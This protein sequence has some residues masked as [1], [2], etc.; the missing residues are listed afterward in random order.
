MRMLQQQ[1]RRAAARARV[2]RRH[3]AQ[4]AGCGRLMFSSCAT[5]KSYAQHI[6]ESSLGLRV[7]QEGVAWKVDIGVS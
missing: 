4:R 5:L 7:N 6:C 1:A 3:E 2:R